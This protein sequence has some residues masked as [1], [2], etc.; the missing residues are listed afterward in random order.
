MKLRR[1]SRGILAVVRGGGHIEYFSPLYN[2]ESPTQVALIL[3]A[4][5]CEV[6]K[7][8]RPE[9]W[10]RFYISYDNMCNLDRLK[11]LREHLPLVG[12]FANI[13]LGVN[14]FLEIGLSPGLNP[15]SR[16]KYL[17]SNLITYFC[18]PR[19]SVLK[20]YSVYYY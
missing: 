18:F 8:V 2:S 1:W 15:I 6:L 12:S 3:I 14:F 16:K 17:I 4:F 11:L 13:C 5:L 10:D 9:L 20:L 7:D 19:A